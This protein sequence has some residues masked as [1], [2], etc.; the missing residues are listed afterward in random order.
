[1]ADP[2]PSDPSAGYGGTKINKNKK[3]SFSQ[4][5]PVQGP[6]PGYRPPQ[7]QPQGPPPSPPPSP[8]QMNRQIPPPVQQ[9]QSVVQQGPPPMQQGP[10]P[11]GNE[12][13][14]P[15]VKSNFAK[16]KFGLLDSG[17]KNALL[18]IVLFIV[19]NSKI[20]WR[21]VMKLTFMGSVEPSMIALFVNSIIAGVAYYI[22]TKYILK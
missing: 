13:N 22:I 12:V 9:I 21:Q 2:I 8:P 18:V 4:Q 1:M 6:P 3:V 15:V 16:S 19:L 20:V 7:G 17:F 5:E 14:I 11:R 10:P